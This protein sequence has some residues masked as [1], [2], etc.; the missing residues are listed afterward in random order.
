MMN[1]D[2]FEGKW[3]EMKGKVQQKWGKLTDDDMDR[4]EGKRTE[5]EGRVQERYGRTKDEAKREVD[6][7]IHRL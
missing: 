4:I 2:Q 3:K 6:D 1:N 7:F 5:L